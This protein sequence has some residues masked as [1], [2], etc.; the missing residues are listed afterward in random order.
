[1]YKMYDKSSAIKEIQIY[2]DKIGVSKLYISPNGIFDE[3][4]KAAVM[5]FQRE[6]GIQAT[7]IIDKKSFD[8]LYK[9]YL[10]ESDVKKADNKTRQNN[11]KEYKLGDYGDDVKKLNEM[12]ILLLEYF[13][14]FHTIRSSSYYSDSTEQARNTALEIFGLDDT[15]D[16]AMFYRRL[17]KEIE[18]IKYEKKMFQTE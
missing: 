13:G 8:L 2:L 15:V 16:F 1:M 6:N 12:L 11:S 17:E 4:T 10:K 18:T 5:N 3:E 9:E 7:G 14:L